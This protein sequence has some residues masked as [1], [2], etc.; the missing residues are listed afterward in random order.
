MAR[1]QREEQIEQLLEPAFRGVHHGGLVE[2]GVGKSDKAHA[3]QRQALTG[4]RREQ[5]ATVDAEQARG[6]LPQA[7]RRREDPRAD[8]AI[9]GAAGQE[10]ADSGGVPIGGS[11]LIRGAEEG[12]LVKD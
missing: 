7:R 2:G 10:E 8:R 4:H 6:L 9:P 3:E 11:A 5:V 12:G 1:R